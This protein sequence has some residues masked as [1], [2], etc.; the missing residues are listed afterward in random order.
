MVDGFGDV[1][2]TLGYV[3]MMSDWSHTEPGSASISKSRLVLIE[4]VTKNDVKLAGNEMSVSSRCTTL[5]CV[6]V[7]LGVCVG[8]Y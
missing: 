6:T 8:Y 1:V 3:C 7:L 2:L 4:S 5:L